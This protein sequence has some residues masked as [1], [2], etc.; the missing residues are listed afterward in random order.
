MPKVSVVM[1]VYNSSKYLGEAIESILKQTF[2]D[3]EFLI[4]NEYGS[5]DG[6]SEIIE[7][8]AQKDNRVIFIQND[9]KLGLG[10]SLN[11]GVKLA[12]GE[13]IARMDAD[14]LAHPKRFKLQVEA[15]DN[16]PSVGICGTYQLHFGKDTRWIHKPPVSNEQC[17]ANLLFYCDICHSTL[18]LRRKV[19][20]DNNLFY[21]NNYLAEDF[22]LWSRATAVTNFMTIPKILGKYRWGDGNISIAKHDKLIEES[23]YLVAKEIKQNLDLDISKNDYYIIGGWINPF[24]EEK[25]KKKKEEMLKRLKV[26]LLRIWDKNKVVKF[27]DDRCLLNILSA[28]WKWCVYNEA[29]NNPQN[30]KN[31]DEVFDPNYKPSIWFKIKRFFINN[32]TIESKIKKV[33][34]KICEY[35][36]SRRSKND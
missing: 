19:F 31:I 8:Y 9:K 15:L 10:D 2:K 12:K 32:P 6:S 21:D 26:I 23:G 5:D 27:Y 4:I 17:K 13:Y 30:I 33:H 1:P 36:N 7:E 29:W 24:F 3:F 16:N 25:D 11:K 22:E 20:I 14:D 18:M 35:I 34:K 28:K